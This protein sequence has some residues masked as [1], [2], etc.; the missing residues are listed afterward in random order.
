MTGV[1]TVSSVRVGTWNLLNGGLDAGDDARLWQQME[2]LSG[3]DLDLLGTQE[4]N[5]GTRN[6][7]LHETAH[8]LGMTARFRIRSNHHGCD[9]VIMVRERDGLRVLEERHDTGGTW[10][11]ALGN[12]RLILDGI[13]Q[14]EFLN[15]HL[16]PSQPGRRE[17][18]AEAF[19]LFKHRP[20]IAV[21]DFNAV[22]ASWDDPDTTGIDPAH[23]MAKTDRRAAQAI[24]R[25]GFIDAATVLG[26]HQ[27]QGDPT[28][29]VGHTG[30][31]KLAYRCDRILFNRL[32]PVRAVDYQVIPALPKASAGDER[33]LSDHHLVVA[34]LHLNDPAAEEEA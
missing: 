13:G 4:A 33:F 30:A 10:W 18:E 5:W 27:G 9:L 31:D 25:A 21:G 15:T 22:A 34:E 17:H 1:S 7:L 24:E 26:P 29:T 19:A 32:L 3:Q 6:T 16:A 11:H 14:V 12:V 2:L 20:A 28:P 23:A 8:W